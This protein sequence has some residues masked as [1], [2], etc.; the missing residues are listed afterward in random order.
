MASIH[1]QFKLFQSIFKCAI[2]L[3]IYSVPPC[4]FTIFP[5]LRSSYKITPRLTHLCN[6]R[7]LRCLW[8]PGF[9]IRSRNM[10]FLLSF[11]F[12]Y[13]LQKLRNFHDDIR[14]VFT[15]TL[16]FIL[17]SETFFVAIFLPPIITMEK[18]TSEIHIATSLNGTFTKLTPHKVSD[19]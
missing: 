1:S 3:A 8:S 10:F 6:G 7:L 11:H 14:Q 13:P 19:I 15:N 16:P 5:S 17:L 4:F 2:Q 18:Q 12:P 9:H